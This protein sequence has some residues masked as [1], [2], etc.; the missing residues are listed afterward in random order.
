MTR[1]GSLTGSDAAA[2]GGS[3]KTAWCVRL[4]ADGLYFDVLDARAV[5]GA[6][7]A[8]RRPSGTQLG[9]VFENSLPVPIES[10]HAV[11]H[12]M[13]DGL[14]LA[15]AADRALLDSLPSGTLAATPDA[16]PDFVAQQHKGRL[17][18]ASEINL[19]VGEYA[20][21][22]VKE[23]R[24]RRTVLAVA[25]TALVAAALS[26]GMQRRIDA[27]DRAADAAEPIEAAVL[28]G[29]LGPAPPTVPNIQRRMAL[30]AERRRLERTRV[31]G[32]ATDLPDASEHLAAALAA[33]P[34]QPDVRIDSLSANDAAV[35]IRGNAAEPA[36]AQA[37][38]ERL[39]GVDGFTVDQPQF[40]SARGRIAF[41]VKLK[42]DKGGAEGMSP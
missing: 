25:A 10:V 42:R 27:A 16:L 40:S 7:R 36:Q 31:A 22:P 6:P 32:G 29:V 1:A 24:R 38:A 18:R 15:C 13:G 34:E 35:T 33:W 5:G 4:P 8:A 21:A 19:L 11:F 20:P 37:L 17:P 3:T 23:R 14:F 41:T 9:L 39:S 28:D 12:R 2:A 26:L 30:V